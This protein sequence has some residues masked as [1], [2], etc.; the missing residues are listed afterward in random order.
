MLR[1]H[2]SVGN[3]QTNEWE[4]IAAVPLGGEVN[5]VYSL[6]DHELVLPNG[7]RLVVTVAIT[8]GNQGVA[9]AVRN[10]ATTLLQ[11][12]AFKNDASGYDPSITF[13][14]PQGLHVTLMVGP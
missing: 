13:Y 3:I 1:L 9:I 7:E 12:T 4:N 5:V 6:R 8:K 2:V 10:A 11:A 14:T